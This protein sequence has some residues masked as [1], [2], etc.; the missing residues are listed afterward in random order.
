MFSISNQ[1]TA[2]QPSLPAI[3][4]LAPVFDMNSEHSKRYTIF[5]YFINDD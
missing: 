2:M 1:I 3:G 5:G 4:S